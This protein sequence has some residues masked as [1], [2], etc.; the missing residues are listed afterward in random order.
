MNDDR[1]ITAHRPALIAAAMLP[2]ALIIGCDS[3]AQAHLAQLPERLIVHW[4]IN[5]PDRWLTTT[6]HTLRVVL[7]TTAL[8]C[9]VPA[10]AAIG[11]LCW[12][13]RRPLPPTAAVRVW[14]IRLFAALLLILCEYFAIIPPALSLL[15]A[16][17]S[18]MR[19]WG[20]SLTIVLIVCLVALLHA[21]H[22]ATRAVE[23]AD[24]RTGS[25]QEG[26][27]GGIYYNPND[28]ALWV[29]KRVG[30]GWTLNFG[31]PWSWLMLAL[32]L[33]VPAVLGFIALR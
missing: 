2:F 13:D 30:I 25:R 9:L 22:Q 3:W 28:R 1:T 17:A 12:S 10:A 24:A 29:E 20:T 27:R 14:R 7:G 8:S 6:P 31:N 33:A 21:G 16:P 19:I 5:G 23:E 26:W 18:A 4:N 11:I 15:N 32:I